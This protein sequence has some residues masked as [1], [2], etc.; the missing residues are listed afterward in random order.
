MS[1][2]QVTHELILDHGGSR[3]VRKRRRTVEGKIFTNSAGKML[4][5]IHLMPES[6]LYAVPIR[7]KAKA[8]VTVKLADFGENHG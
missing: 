5:R 6:I 3:H 2:Y 1:D 4:V 8:D 7:K